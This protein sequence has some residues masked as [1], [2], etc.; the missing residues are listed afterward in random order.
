MNLFLFVAALLGL[1]G[2]ALGA[3]GAHALQDILVARHSL[4]IWKTAVFYHLIHVLAAVLAEILS[5]H[6]NEKRWWRRA[7]T[8]WLLGIILFSGSL[9][10]LALWGPRWL[11]P[12]TPIGGLAL[13]AG[14]GFVAIGA[15]KTP[16]RR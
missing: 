14:W 11:G 2:V 16:P 13:I 6:F 7:G 10:A 4:E 15:F 8:S 9:Y 12:V 3:F 5:A 1:A